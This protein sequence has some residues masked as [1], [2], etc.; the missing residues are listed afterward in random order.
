MLNTIRFE[1]FCCLYAAPY[2]KLTTYKSVTLY[3][4]LC[5][6]RSQD[7]GSQSDLATVAGFQF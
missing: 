6:Y 7:I 5:G 1:V 2:V 3:A 4:V